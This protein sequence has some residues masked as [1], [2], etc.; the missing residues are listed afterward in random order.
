MIDDRDEE[1]FR[2]D[3]RVVLVVR[4]MDPARHRPA[5]GHEGD[6]GADHRPGRATAGI[7]PTPG[8]ASRE[9]EAGANH[10]GASV[11]WGLPQCPAS[12]V[13]VINDAMPG[14]P[15][16]PND[17]L[18]ADLYP[19]DGAHRLRWDAAVGRDPDSG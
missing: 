14:C 15:I 3:E 18:P 7:A 2:N 9:A 17:I 6:A 1:E 11:G 8:Q 4:L 19:H 5:A 13:R 12:L 10:S 16:G